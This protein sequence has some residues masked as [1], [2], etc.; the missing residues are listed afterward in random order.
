[1]IRKISSNKKNTSS[2][3]QPSNSSF[4]YYIHTGQLKYMMPWSMDNF[5]TNSVKSQ[6]SIIDLQK[7]KRKLKEQISDASLI[8]EQ[9]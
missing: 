9:F 3:L 7:N 1:M 6:S 8:I 2:F 4:I 5:E